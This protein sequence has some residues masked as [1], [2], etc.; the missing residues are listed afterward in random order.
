MVRREEPP[1]ACLERSL[2]LAQVIKHSRVLIAISVLVLV[3]VRA[4]ASLSFRPRHRD[5]SE[6]PLVLQHLACRALSPSDLTPGRCY[7]G[8]RRRS[9][10]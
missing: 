4:L 9:K 8:S 5:G 2:L 7:G 10:A 3:L 1:D 6:A